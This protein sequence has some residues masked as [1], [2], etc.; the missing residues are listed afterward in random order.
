MKTKAWAMGF[1]WGQLTAQMDC[2]CGRQLT[3]LADTVLYQIVKWTAAKKKKFNWSRIVTGSKS[4]DVSHKEIYKNGFAYVYYPAT[5]TDCI[6]Q[7]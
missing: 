1:K 3:V 4:E 6:F 7:C 2:L 5:I